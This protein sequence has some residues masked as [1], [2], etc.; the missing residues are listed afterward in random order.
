MAS[1]K[2]GVSTTVR[3]NLTP[4]SSISTVDA[5]SCTVFLIFS[6]ALGTIRSVTNSKLRFK[7]V[8]YYL[9]NY[10]DKD[11]SRTKSW[12]RLTCRVRI[13]QRP[14]KWIRNLSWLTSC[15]P[16]KWAEFKMRVLESSEYFSFTYLVGQVGKTD[17]TRGIMAG[18]EI[19]FQI[20]RTHFWLPSRCGAELLAWRRKTS[21]TNWLMFVDFE[22]NNLQLRA[23][24]SFK[25]PLLFSF[26]R[27]DISRPAII[28]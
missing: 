12:S 2:P 20:R 10:R 8:N 18:R 27:L 22:I 16:E 13:H 7:N 28:S 4:R 11:L 6:A 21:L 17:I 5:S 14:S 15:A 1:P 19:G 23:C 3:R 24:S 26:S 25:L 9:V